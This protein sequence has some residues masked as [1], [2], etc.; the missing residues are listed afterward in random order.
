MMKLTFSKNEITST[1]GAV[2]PLHLGFD[3]EKHEELANKDI[4]WSVD[5]D[6]VTLRSFSGSNKKGFNN[7]VLLILSQAPWGWGSW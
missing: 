4:K 3:S 5:S 6:A 7:G 1:V 2:L